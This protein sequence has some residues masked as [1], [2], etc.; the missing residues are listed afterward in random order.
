LAGVPVVVGIGE[1][2]LLPLLKIHFFGLGLSE[3]G[4]RAYGDNI[5]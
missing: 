4:L 1:G 3:H 2:R 5:S